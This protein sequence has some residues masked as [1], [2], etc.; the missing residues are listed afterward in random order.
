D[1]NA[2]DPGFTDMKPG[3]YGYKEVAKAVQ[4]GFISGKTAK[5]GSKYFEP[6]GTLTRAQMAKI[7]V[8]GYGLKETDQKYSFTDVTDKH[9]AKDYIETLAS[10]N[11]TTGYPNGTFDPQGF[12]SRQHF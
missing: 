8:E 11:I 10:N 12:L 1:F 3:S 6:N 7:L 5:N 4:L 9:W 2:P